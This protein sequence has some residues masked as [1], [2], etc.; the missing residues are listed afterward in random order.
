MIQEAN[1]KKYGST[2]KLLF[3]LLRNPFFIKEGDEVERKK[4][5]SFVEDYIKEHK[6]VEKFTRGDLHSLLSKLAKDKILFDNYKNNQYYLIASNRYI[7]LKKGK[8]F[9]EFDGK[10][11]SIID[12]REQSTLNPIISDK[13]VKMNQNNLTFYEWYVSAFNSAKNNEHPLTR[14]LPQFL[15]LL[16][17]LL[18]KPDIDFQIKVLCSLALSYL[19]IEDDYYPD[20]EP[21]GYLDDMFIIT[22][23]LKQIIDKNP[24][25]LKQYWAYDEDISIL[26]QNTYDQLHVIVKNDLYPILTVV[27]MDQYSLYNVDKIQDCL[28]K[29]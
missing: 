14:Y 2:D 19:V 20:S 24:D 13:I 28:S 5:I 3:I 6:G 1:I 17:N 10:K 22:Y 18:T 26:I 23:A 27:G 4:I 12:K 8:L 15:N 11:Y 29:K 25:L 21:N 7:S 9:I 16:S